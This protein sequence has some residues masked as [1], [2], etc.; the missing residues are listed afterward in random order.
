MIWDDSGAAD[1][2]WQPVPDGKGHYRF[3]NY[4]TG[5]VLAVAGMSKAGGAQVVQWTDGSVTSGCTASGPRQPGRI[6]T[7][8]KLTFR[9]R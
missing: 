3:A 7:A 8:R 9:V 4:G 2:L 1:Q 6:G 5:L